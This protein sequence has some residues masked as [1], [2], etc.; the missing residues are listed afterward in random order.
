MSESVRVSLGQARRME[1]RSSV[2]F[3]IDPFSNAGRTCYVRVIE[4]HRFLAE[5]VS[6]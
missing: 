3:V 6:E 2:A 4:V 1:G 5:I